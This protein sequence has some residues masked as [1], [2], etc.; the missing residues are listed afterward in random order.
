MN[1]LQKYIQVTVPVSLAVVLPPKLPRL[2]ILQ[3]FTNCKNCIKALPGRDV[4]V[5]CTSYGGSP[6][7][8]INIFKDGELEKNKTSLG[9]VAGI[10]FKFKA[11]P[12]Y[13]WAEISC[14][15]ENDATEVPLSTSAT[16]YFYRKLYSLNMLKLDGVYLQ[17]WM[18]YSLI[19]SLCLDVSDY[20]HY[21]YVSVLIKFSQKT[22]LFTFIIISSP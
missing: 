1:N 3:N 13:N 17:L 10:A 21:V 12:E 11:T 18:P 5:A 2:S 15:V 7:V 20:S 16:V 9:T 4:V 19:I 6:P 8:V 22:S 14:T